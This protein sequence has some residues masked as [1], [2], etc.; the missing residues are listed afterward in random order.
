MDI[1][2][3]ESVQTNIDSQPK[4]PLSPKRQSKSIRKKP[5]LTISIEDA[6]R[7]WPF[8]RL[9]G[10]LLERLHKQTIKETYED[11]PL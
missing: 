8:T 3:G 9:D 1:Y 10:G 2:E 6:K 7:N 5:S 4:K 11:A